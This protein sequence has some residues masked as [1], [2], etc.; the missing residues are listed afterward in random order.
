MSYSIRQNPSPFFTAGRPAGVRGIV[1]HHAAT[2]DFDGIGRTFKVAG[3]SAGYG[4][5]Q[6]NTVDQYVAD[7]NTGY[8]AGNWAANQAY[9]GIEHVNS[10][11]S[12]T[13]WPVA[14][15]TLN[16]SVELSR[17][18]VA[19]HGLGK[20]VP[21]QNLFPHNHFSPTFCPGVIKAKLDWYAEQVN[22]ATG[23]SGGGS[24]PA[25]SRRSNEDIAT[26]V[27]N[28]KWGNNPGR[29]SSLAA[30]GYDPNTIQAIVNAR[31][32]GGSAPAPAQSSVSEI[33]RQVIAGAWGNGPSRQANLERAG[34]NYA[35]VQ[36]EVNRQLGVGTTVPSGGIIS[37]GQNVQFVTPVDYN[38]T[39][40][41]VSGTY[42]VM[43]VR[44]DRAVV[45]RG[46]AV[47]AAAKTT[48]LRRV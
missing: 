35:S 24:A 41:G 9:I 16:T 40:L 19:R 25:P 4:V 7:G 13:G 44:G 31:L 39:R 10:G 23:N 5:S 17:D 15:Q 30:A 22:A 27:L 43:E 18:I 28:G 48:N 45:G 11:G 20:L 46:G 29:S 38:G 2:T 32:G 1:L 3:V 8:H 21:F 37:Q 14:D 6:I 34:Y 33:A 42:Q 26:E 47:T 36:A 12:Q